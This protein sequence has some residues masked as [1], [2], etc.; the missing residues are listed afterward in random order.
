MLVRD[1]RDR[2][3][4]WTRMHFDVTSVASNAEL[5]QLRANPRFGVERSLEAILIT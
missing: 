3:G 5:M 2:P 1:P 4:R